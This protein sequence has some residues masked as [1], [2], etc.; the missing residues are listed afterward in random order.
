MN[1]L[2]IYLGGSAISFYVHNRP[3]T[4]IRRKW[5]GGTGGT[6]MLPVDAN[7]TLPAFGFLKWHEHASI[8]GRVLRHD[9]CVVTSANS[10]TF[11]A[12][13]IR[14]S[15]SNEYPF[16]IYWQLTC[17][18]NCSGSPW[19]LFS[20]YSFISVPHFC[21]SLICLVPWLLNVCSDDPCCVH[22]V[23]F[24]SFFIVFSALTLKMSTL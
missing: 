19:S 15:F 3:L 23:I 1:R 4:E 21:F 14:G 20:Y 24:N 13:Y 2:S 5:E 16:Q 6:V 10:Y 8:K 22:T 17:H 12:R 9:A 18:E 11:N 7:R